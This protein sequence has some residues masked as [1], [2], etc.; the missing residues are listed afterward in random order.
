MWCEHGDILVLSYEGSVEGDAEH[1][2]VL[3][4]AV[5]VDLYVNVVGEDQ[6]HVR[7]DLRLRERLMCVAVRALK[8]GLTAVAGPCGIHLYYREK[9]SGDTRF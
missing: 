3:H 4:R 5:V 8:G 2:R 7:T 9:L 1:D 6:R